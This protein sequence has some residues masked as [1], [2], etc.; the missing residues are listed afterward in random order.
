M[1]YLTDAFGN[2]SGS[3]ALGRQA[4]RALDEPASGWRKYSARSSKRSSSQ[5]GTESINAAIKGVALAQQQAGLGN[6]IVTTTSSTTP[7]STRA[8]GLRVR[9]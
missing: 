3:Y 7:C 6:H 5:G 8:S 4:A 2:P 1:P 9:F